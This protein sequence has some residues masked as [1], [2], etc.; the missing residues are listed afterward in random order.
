MKK[1]VFGCAAASLLL[2]TLA[3]RGP[4]QAPAP[5]QPPP[6][7]QPSDISTTISGGP[8][9]PPR[10]AVPTFLALSN[11][12]ETVGVARIITD[13]LWDDLAFE[14]EFDL[15]PRDVYTTIPAA[16]SIDDVPF[17][18]WREINADGVII[19]TVQKVGNTMQ[20]RVRLFN[21]RSRQ[22]AF[23][24]E[25]GGSANGRLYA[26]T[27]AD[28]VHLQQRGLHGVAR[29]RLTFDSDR[30]GERLK[31]TVESRSVKEI[32]ISD[33]DGENQRRI[34]TSRSLNIKPK[35]SPDARSIA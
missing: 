28:D 15:I 18:R 29:T 27:I 32:Y 7:Q 17:D 14:R 30:D 20:V 11:D 35:W 8:G 13:V 12:A 9:V 1:L 4:Q 26:H 16:K 10:L 6:A 19:G 2:V 33:Y 21:T 34:T 31:G 23:G 24:K 3:A 25:Y 22:Q 5:A